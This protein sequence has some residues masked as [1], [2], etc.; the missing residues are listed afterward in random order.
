MGEKL[1]TT[2]VTDRLYG[3][4]KECAK[5]GLD[6]GFKVI[7]DASFLHLSQ[8]ERFRELA[9]E[10]GIPFIILACHANLAALHAR[11]ET[12]AR[13][14]FDPSEATRAVLEHQLATQDDL[15]AHE[16]EYAMTIDTNWLIS[17][18]AGIKAVQAR[19]DTT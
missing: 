13:V 5:A 16:R 12:R 19:L 9:Q 3:H 10:R 17:A 6:A 4:L 2:D 14:G 7:V 8:R 15:T 11:L 1:Y 18:D